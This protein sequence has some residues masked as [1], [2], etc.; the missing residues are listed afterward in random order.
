MF[1]QQLP[2]RTFY[3]NTTVHLLLDYYF[4]QSTL[5]KIYSSLTKAPGC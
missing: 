4:K 3:L 5:E 2:L 1:L